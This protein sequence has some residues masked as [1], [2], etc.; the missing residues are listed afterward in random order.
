LRSL[1]IAHSGVP[2]FIGAMR[3]V[4]SRAAA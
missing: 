1:R 4:E 3:L 2:S